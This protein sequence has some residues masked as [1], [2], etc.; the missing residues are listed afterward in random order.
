MWGFRAPLL[1]T[2]PGGPGGPKGPGTPSLPG[3]PARPY[4][5]N[6]AREA[7]SDLETLLP[8]APSRLGTPKAGPS[9]PTTDSPSPYML[10]PV[11]HPLSARAWLAH[12]SSRACL[13]REPNNTRSTRG[14]REAQISLKSTQQREGMVNAGPSQDSHQNSLFLLPPAATWPAAPTTGDGA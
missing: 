2:D 9:P 12:L 7:E 11:P 10:F 14:A 4:Q 3:G 1:T 6:G 5:K 8:S 13:T